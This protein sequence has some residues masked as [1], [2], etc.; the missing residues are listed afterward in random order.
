MS[1]S[2]ARRVWYRLWQGTRYFVE[3]PSAE[4]EAL[5]AEVLSPPLLELY[6]RMAPRDRAHA[7]RVCR[8][9]RRWGV[10]ERT[11]LQAALL[12]DVGKAGGVPWIARVVYVLLRRWAPACVARLERSERPPALLRPLVRL[13]RHPA[14]GAELAAQA[15]A[16]ADVV[17]LIGGHQDGSGV[18][19]RLMPA[20]RLLQRAD[21]AA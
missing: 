7:A 11:V 20:L 17:S 18:P 15:G 10:E 2:A 8:A 6:N 16:P 9:L 21:E 13:A 3:R 19:P 4:D 5:A 12:H 1:G 14:I